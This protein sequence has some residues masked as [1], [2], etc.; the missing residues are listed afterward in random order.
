MAIMRRSFA[1]SNRHLVE[2]IDLMVEAKTIILL[3][4]AISALV[5]ATYICFATKYYEVT[6]RIQTEIIDLISKEEMIFGRIIEKSDFNWELSRINHKTQVQL[7]TDEIVKIEDY[8]NDFSKQTKLVK[9]E[10]IQ[11]TN[12][13][14]EILNS[15]Q[16][17]N[18][19]SEISRDIVEYRSL[20]FFLKTKE[21]MWVDESSFTKQLIKPIKYSSG[22]PLG[23][24][25]GVLCGFIF[26]L[27]RAAYDECDLDGSVRP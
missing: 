13:R 19:S 15:M 26:V 9:D 11:N 4:G 18:P 10:L 3:S 21:L 25:F 5:A 6:F 20:L 2:L 7:V 1:K 17:I 22:L 24:I 12:E 23:F 16:K 27:V 14:I 8:M